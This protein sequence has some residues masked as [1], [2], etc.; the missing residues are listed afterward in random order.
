MIITM[1][2]LLMIIIIILPLFGCYDEREPNNIAYITAVGIDKAEDAKNYYFTIQFAK[3]TQISGGASEEGGKGG[4]IVENVSVEAPTLYAA[5]STINHIVS[6]TMS[7]AHIKLVVFSDEVAREGVGNIM[8]TMIRSEEIRPHVYLA[9]ARNSSSEYL[10]EIKPVVEI[11]PAKYYQLV[12]ENNSFSGIPKNPSE[13]FYFYETLPERDSVM[14][15]VSII[16]AGQQNNAQQN[17]EQQDGG[18]QQQNEEG[19]GSQEAEINEDQKNAPVNEEGY[20]YK[21]KNYLAG[22]VGIEEKN[23][24]E[25]MG[26]AIFSG[27]RLVG[28]MGSI[29]SGLYN[30]LSGNYTKGY[31]T[32]NSDKTDTPITIKAEMEK[33]P[34]IKYDKENNSAEIKFRLE[35]DFVSLASDYLTEK[36]IE[37]FENNAEKLINEAAEHFLQRTSSE[38]G[39]DIVGIGSVAKMQFLT[40]RDFNDFKW[41]D[42][43]KDLKFSVKSDIKIR[44][45]GLTIRNEIK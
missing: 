32:F 28:Y 23:K 11:N 26:M 38:F 27:D 45:T 33:K 35:C 10:N 43:Y 13:N 42:K 6:K 20:E 16:N 22:E 4:D 17:G 9:V 5:I 1:K 44:R 40:S 25:A 2:K 21:V 31:L 41:E 12:F 30:M 36:H 8:Q 29:E 15:V 19:G 37:E 34:R 18:M 14:P 3:P 39:T 7:M 24:A